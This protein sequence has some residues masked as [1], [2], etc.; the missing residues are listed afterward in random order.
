MISAD[1]APILSPITNDSSRSNPI[2]H[3]PT[4]TL[5]MYELSLHNAHNKGEGETTVRYL[6]TRSLNTRDRHLRHLAPLKT[7]D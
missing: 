6:R 5:Q 3:P 4:A 1:R 2:M 7:V